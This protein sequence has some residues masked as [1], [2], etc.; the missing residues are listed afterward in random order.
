MTIPDFAIGL[1]ATSGSST[2]TTESLYNGR[3]RKPFPRF[4]SHRDRPVIIIQPHTNCVDVVC[5]APDGSRIA[6]VAADGWLKMW[7]PGELHTNRPIWEVDAE[8]GEAAGRLSFSR[9]LTHAQFFPDGKMLLTSGWRRHLRAWDTKT[10]EPKWDVLKPHGFSGIGILAIAPDGGRAA[11]AGGHLGTAEKVYVIDPK[12]Q[13]V[14]KT[15][16][17]HDDACGALSASSEGLAS[18]SADKHVKFWAWD[19]GRCYHDLALR[20][21]V[22]GLEFAPDGARLAAAGGS[23]VMVWDMV[24]PLRGKGRRKPGTLRQFRGHTEQIQR[25][26]FSPDGKT[27]ASAAHDGTVRTWDVSSGAELR[28]FAPKVGELHHVAFSP[29]G[30]TL[31]FS[32]EKGHVG[33][34]DLDD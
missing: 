19:S 29:D 31:A 6:S 24:A 23:M 32:S 20:G 5:F 13:E 11:F 16:R 3:E 27:L 8:A 7:S 12:T 14:V 17:G 21:I 33:L 2:S 34:L 18:G 9:G 4:A 1:R 30:L 22:R 28:T 25:L 10:G 15:L 26:A